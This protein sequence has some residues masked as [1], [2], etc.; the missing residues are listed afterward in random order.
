[1]CKGLGPPRTESPEHRPAFRLP[2]LP[3]AEVA[4]RAPQ[5]AHQF[6]RTRT[7]GASVSGTSMPEDALGPPGATFTVTFGPSSA[8]PSRQSRQGVLSPAPGGSLQ[9]AGPLLH[10]DRQTSMGRCVCIGG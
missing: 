8:E 7:S 6:P 4:G 10:L 3:A 1:M 9:A 2:H 5:T